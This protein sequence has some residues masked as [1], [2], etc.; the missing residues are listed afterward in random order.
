[1]DGGAEQVDVIGFTVVGGN[2]GIQFGTHADSPASASG[3]GG[4]FGDT[5][6]GYAQVGIEAIGTGSRASVVG[7]TVR[8][9][10]TAGAANAPI[11]VQISDGP[12]PMSHSTPSRKTS[13]IA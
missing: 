5:V 8:G 1:M 4:A 11:G 3:S 2:A 13:A 7:D 6:F 10:G 9:P 12:G